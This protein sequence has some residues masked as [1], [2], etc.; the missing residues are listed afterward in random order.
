MKPS[1]IK[2]QVIAVVAGL[3]IAGAVGASAASLG[4]VGGQDLGADTGDV[5]AC[6]TDGIDVD[7]TPVFDPAS[8][9]YVAEFTLADI[10]LDCVNN[11]Y[12]L[13][14]FQKGVGGS[15][16]FLET[17]R[18]RFTQQYNRA[19][20]GERVAR[21]FYTSTFPAEIIEGVALEIVGQQN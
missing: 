14:I 20:D 9:E 1:R 3:A 15:R 18:F 17:D 11:P 21:A 19:S 8:G 6:D 2:K 10:D 7:W 4:G 16:A 5:E 13:S 12:K